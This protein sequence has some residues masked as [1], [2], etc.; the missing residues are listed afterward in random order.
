MEYRILEISLESVT[1]KAIRSL[2]IIC[3]DMSVLPRYICHN[4]PYDMWLANRCPD[5][6]PIDSRID[7]LNRLVHP[8]STD[9]YEHQSKFSV[10]VV[11]SRAAVECRILAISLESVTSK[12]IRSTKIIYCDMSVLPRYICLHFL[13]DIWLGSRYPNRC[14]IYTLIDTH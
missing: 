12:A 5:R 7:T 14:P 3:C 1:P 8:A 9:K 4:L 10:I 11:T 13:C 2:K 6:Y